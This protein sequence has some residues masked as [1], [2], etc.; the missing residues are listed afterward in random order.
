MKKLK[1]SIKSKWKEGP[2]YLRSFDLY[3]GFILG[4]SI[5]LAILVSLQL[6]R[7][8][9]GISLVIGMFVSAPSDVPG[10]VRHRVNGIIAALLLSICLTFLINLASLKE[11]TLMPLLPT[12]VFLVSFIAV[13]GF[14]ASLV[15]FSGLTAI[16]MSLAHPHQGMDLYVHIGLMGVGGLWYLG[17]SHVS[18]LLVQR[19]FTESQMAECMELTAKYLKTRGRLALVKGDRQKLED[20]LFDLQSEINSI[21]EV[22]REILLSSKR[23]SGQSNFI[24]RQVIVFIELVDILELAIGNLNNVH[25]LQ[26]HK[27]EFPKLMKIFT[28]LI[29]RMAGRLDNLANMIRVRNKNLPDQDAIDNLIFEAKAEID[30]YSFQTEPSPPYGQVLLLQNVHGYFKKQAQKIDLIGNVL[31]NLAEQDQARM[32]NKDQRKFITHQDYDWKT[33]T[34]NLNLRS[35]MFKHSLRISVTVLAGYLIGLIFPLQN[36][37]WILL[38]LVVI[39][40]PGYSLTRQ[41]SKNRLYGTLIGGLVAVAVIYTTQNNYIYAGLAFVTFVLGFSLV[42]KNF[43]SSAIFLTLNVIFLYALIQ[44]D[45]LNVIQFRVLDTLIGAF[46]AV[47][48]NS[49]LWPAWG[50]QNIHEYFSEAIEANKLY[51]AEINNYYHHKNYNDPAYKLSRKEA[52][53][54]IG[55]LSAA[56]QEMTQEP[57]SKQKDLARIY[58]LVVLNHTFLSLLASLGSFMRNNRTTEASSHFGKYIAAISHNLDISLQLLTESELTEGQPKIHVTQA[59]EYLERAYNQLIEQQAQ[60]NAS[61]MA[62]GKLLPS[63]IQEVKLISDQLKWLYTISDNMKKTARR[64]V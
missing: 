1:G 21:H 39:M 22:L 61:D 56:F 33:I 36:P 44:P 49:F 11:W 43:Q 63:K 8:E 42:R 6:G 54:A 57:K 40:R 60:E 20:E 14:R 62:S 64:I 50:F 24:R 3:K 48:A 31:N 10:S 17:F 37:Y 26:K 53:L 45:P 29:F 2:R 35:P 16:I 28:R 30:K 52:F 4:L 19:S 47:I 9:T 18:H 51:L 15:S 34:E 5:L 46:L 23:H 7:L 13:F 32:S 25:L 59:Q 55:N 12:L 58:E 38:T 27:E 41:R